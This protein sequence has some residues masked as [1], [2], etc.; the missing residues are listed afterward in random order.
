MI[1]AKNAA[2]LLNKNWKN[3][4]TMQTIDDVRTRVV[5]G[6]KV[7]NAAEEFPKTMTSA[8]VNRHHNEL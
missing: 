2:L 3:R 4:E 7:D 5:Q 6:E 1:S 8:D